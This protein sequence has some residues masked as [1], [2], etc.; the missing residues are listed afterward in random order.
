M[1]ASLAPTENHNTSSHRTHSEKL[2][3]STLLAGNIG[4]PLIDVVEKTPT[5]HYRRGT[6]QL[7]ARINR[8]LP[9]KHQ[10]LLESHS[11]HLDRTALWKLMPRPRPAF[12]KNNCDDFA[13]LNADDPASTPYAQRSR[14]FSGLAANSASRKAHSSRRENY[15]PPS[16]EEEI[17][18]SNRNPASRRAQSRECSRRRCGYTARRRAAEWH[19]PKPSAPFPGVEHRSKFVAERNGVRY[20]TIRKIRTVDAT[21]KALDAFPGRVLIVLG[22]K[23]QRQRLHRSPTPLREK[24]NPW[25]Y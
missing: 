5:K 1:L 10:R 16:R 12:S 24:S 18:P 19:R 9:F 14:K 4:T 20:S 3:F 15:F 11:D 21:L 17:I 6:K 22:G 23:R 25:R 8:N 7:P 13:I 2:R